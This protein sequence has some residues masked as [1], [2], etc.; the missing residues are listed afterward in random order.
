LV[1][2]CLHLLN[3]R[4]ITADEPGSTPGWVINSLKVFLFCLC[5]CAQA[6]DRFY[7][8]YTATEVEETRPGCTGCVSAFIFPGQCQKSKQMDLVRFICFHFVQ[9]VP[10]LLWNNLVRFQA[11]SYTMGHSIFF[12]HAG[13][14]VFCRPLILDIK[15]GNKTR[16][17][18]V[19][20]CFRYGV[21]QAKL[22]QTTGSIPGWVIPNSSGFFLPKSSAEFYPSCIGT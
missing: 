16:L 5:L 4:E 3:Y 20:I 14:P 7:P 11:G 1:C 22:Q 15:Y 13:H 12:L 10:K 6:I 17:H 9:A 18:E 8:C 2:I 19:C 21:N